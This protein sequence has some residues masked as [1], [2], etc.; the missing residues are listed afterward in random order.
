[1]NVGRTEL[2]RTDTSVED[3]KNAPTSI[4]IV[5]QRQNDEK[6][7]NIASYIASVLNGK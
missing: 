3:Y 2:M 7:S 1:M 6:L 4:Q 5:G